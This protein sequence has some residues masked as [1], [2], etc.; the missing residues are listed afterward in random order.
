MFCS[1]LWCEL[2]TTGF[3]P[4]STG[5]D[6]KACSQCNKAM[7]NEL[8]YLNQPAKNKHRKCLHAYSQY[9]YT[10]LYYSRWPVSSSSLFLERRK[11]HPDTNTHMWS[12]DFFP[13]MLRIVRERTNE[14]SLEFIFFEVKKCR[15][16]AC[17]GWDCS[18]Q[19]GLTDEIMIPQ[20]TIFNVNYRFQ[21]LGFRVAVFVVWVFGFLFHRFRVSIIAL[22]GQLRMRGRANEFNVCKEQYFVMPA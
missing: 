2:K 3:D 13:G 11:L 16:L 7:G 18:V 19:P 12:K 15:T 5:F 22:P 10:H 4:K 9:S 6:P 17:Q 21:V 8:L 1:L 20:P 14:G